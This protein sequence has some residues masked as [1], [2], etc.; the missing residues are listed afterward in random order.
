MKK[1]S[2]S[3]EIMKML[4]SVQRIASMAITGVL[5]TAPTDLLDLHVGIWPVHLLF[6][7]ACHWATM[8][9]T[10]LLPLYPLHSLYRKR[11]ERDIKTHRSLLHK[12]AALSNIALDSLEDLDPVQH[13]CYDLI[14]PGL[15]PI[16]KPHP[17]R[18]DPPGVSAQLRHAMR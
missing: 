8:R 9:I 16:P 5:P 1:T 15:R 12:L 14:R 2:G 3:V 11:V 7:W 13:P 10:S 6:H 4:P 18:S 17:A